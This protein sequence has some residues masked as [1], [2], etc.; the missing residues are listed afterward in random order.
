M[1]GLI[2]ASLMSV[3]NVFN[4]VSRKKVLD[5]QFD[6]GLVSFWSKVIAFFAFVLAIIILMATC[7]TRP[8][9][10]D[11][12]KTMSVPPLCAFLLYLTLN[13]LLEGTAILLNLRPFRFP[14]CLTVCRSWPSPL[15]FCCRQAGSCS[16]NP[17]LP[18]WSSESRWS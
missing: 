7:G 3:F 1:L 4:D 18:E 2:L 6:A 12:G 5:H 8:E 11:I 17:S 15:C 9:L 10:P 13:A 14:P 16:A